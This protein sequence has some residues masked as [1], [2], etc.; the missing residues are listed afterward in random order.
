MVSRVPRSSILREP[1]EEFWA[2]ELHPRWCGVVVWARITGLL[3][4][5]TLCYE[6]KKLLADGIL[7]NSLLKIEIQY[8]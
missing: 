3:G 2:S 4:P 1:E 5:S 6:Y 8:P 7:C